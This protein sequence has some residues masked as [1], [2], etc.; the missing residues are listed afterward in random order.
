MEEKEMPLDLIE[1]STH[2]L[3]ENLSKL[4]PPGQDLVGGDENLNN[5]LES[6]EKVWNKEEEP[7]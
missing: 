3:I 5:T 7:L 2:L 6:I 4:Y 1:E